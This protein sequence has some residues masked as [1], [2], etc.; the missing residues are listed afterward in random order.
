MKSISNIIEFCETGK[1][2][3]LEISETYTYNFF[4]PA[5]ESDVRVSYITSFEEHYVYTKKGTMLTALKKIEGHTTFPI[6]FELEGKRLDRVATETVVANLVYDN[7]FNCHGF[8]FLNGQYWFLLNQ[9]KFEILVRENEYTP[10]TKSSLR[11]GGICIYYN[12]HNDL[13]HSAKVIDGIIQSKFGVNRIIT[14]GE[15]EILEK[16]NGSQIDSS[17]TRYYN[18]D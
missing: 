3:L 16:Y 17:K 15:Q 14:R 9:E 5:K 4:H 8:T 13:I 1:I 18:V 10:C 7:S 12:F 2:S 6:V 11:E